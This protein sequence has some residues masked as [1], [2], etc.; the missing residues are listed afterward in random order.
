MSKYKYYSKSDKNQETVGIVEAKSKEHA[1]L[2][3]ATKKDFTL[4]TFQQLFEV[5]KIKQ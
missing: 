1:I 2:K 4:Y 5:E 3:A